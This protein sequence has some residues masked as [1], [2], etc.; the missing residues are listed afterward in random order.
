MD[1]IQRV[2]SRVL[3]VSAEGAVLL[4]LDQDPAHP[5]VLRWGT[6]G[7]GVD[8]GESHEEAAVREL[9]EE[10]GVVAPITALGSPFHTDTLAYSY[11]GVAYVGWSTFYAISLSRQVEVTFAHLE[12][13]EIDNVLEARWLTPDEVR[14]DGRLVVPELPDIMTAAIAAVK[15]AP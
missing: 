11:D 10:T 5:G 6:I 1:P 14:A 12:P 7:G 4:L 13:L 9:F 3:P 8:A 2:T 15:D